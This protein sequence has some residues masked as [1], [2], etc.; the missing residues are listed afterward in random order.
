MALLR[1]QLFLAAGLLLLAVWRAALSRLPALQSSW[2]VQWIAALL[3]LNS[4]AFFLGLSD[5]Y[6]LDGNES[7]GAKL[8]VQYL[9]LWAVV[10]LG[11]YALASVV[12]KVA[13]FGDCPEAA[14]ELAGEIAAAKARLRAAG[15]AF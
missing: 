10:A 7:V 3:G 9:P 6:S 13:T 12:Y 4:V 2:V 8:L 1:Y 14:S 11:V 15:F 5:D